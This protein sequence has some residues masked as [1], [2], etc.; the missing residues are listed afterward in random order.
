MLSPDPDLRDAQRLRDHLNVSLEAC[1]RRMIAHRD[2]PLAAI[3]SHQGRVRYFVKS[4]MFPFVTLKPGDQLPE[5]S[6]AHRAITLGKPGFTRFADTHPYPWTCRTNVEVHEQT[7]L[8]A[9]GHA[10][11]LLWADIPEEEDSDGLAELG[12]PMFR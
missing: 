12:M 9:N 7:R 11:T 10:V 3:W 4:P 6:A 1:V 2:E 8:A 5:A